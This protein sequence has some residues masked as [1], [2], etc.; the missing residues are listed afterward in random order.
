MSFSDH[1]LSASQWDENARVPYLNLSNPAVFV[2]YENDQSILE[3]IKYAQQKRLGGVMVWELGAAF[4]PDN[5]AGE[6]DPLL[7]SI[8]THAF[9]TN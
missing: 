6:K 9:P 2:S 4:F 5:E 7:Q 1:D 8:K 3:K